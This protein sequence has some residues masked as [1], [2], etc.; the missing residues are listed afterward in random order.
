KIRE[1]R[2]GLYKPWIASMDE[3]WTRWLLEQYEYNL[4][5][6][7]NKAIKAGKLNGSFDAIVLPD[8]N[9]EVIVDGK[10][11]RE[12]DAMKYYQEFPPEYAEGISKDGT[13]NL[14]EFVQSGG[15][16]IALAHSGDLLIDEFNIPVRNLLA[17]AKPEDF[18]CPGSLLKVRIDSSHPV[19]Y[20]MPSEG[21]AFVNEAIAYQTALPGMEIQRWV[22]AWYPEEP[23]DILLSGWIRGPE[24]LTRRAAAVALTYGKGR[25]VLIGFRAQHRAQTEGT[26]K[27]LFN[28]I[29]WAGMS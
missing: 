2:V 11:K 15:T 24:K 9:K 17:K 20:G 13:K 23:Q 28:A 7:D 6:V 22:L 1:V 14:K 18:L 27:M 26:F 21:A 5:T 29:H 19:N 10:P 3:G 25:I 8:V 16:L 12:E 4:K